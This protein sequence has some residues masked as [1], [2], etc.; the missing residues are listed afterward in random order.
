MRSTIKFFSSVKLAIV[1]L[2]IITLASILGTLVPQG[3]SAAE[4]AARYGQ[5][6]DLLIRLEVT[7]L[8][9]SWWYMGLLVMFALNIFVC[10]L[11]RLK[12]KLRRAFNPNLE[13]ESKK[14]ASLKIS[15]QWKVDQGTKTYRE[16]VNSV[17]RSKRFRILE[18][19]DEGKLFFLARKK[20]LGVFGSDIVHLG[21]LIII[22]GGI[23]SGMAGFK[24]TLKI[25]EGQ[26]ISVPKK[27]FSLRL[28]KF[29]TE[30]YENGSVKDW[31]STL[32]VVESDRDVLSKVVEVNHPLTHKGVVF[33][34]S[35]Y[36]WDW[37]D[38]SVEIRLTDKSDESVS[39]NITLKIGEKAVLSDRKLE[40]H[41][42]SF[43]P[44]FIL[45]EKNEVATRSREPNN[46]A[47]FIKVMKEGNEIFSGWLFARYRDFARM[48]S[49]EESDLS[50][51]FTDYKAGRFSGIQMAI[52]PGVNLIWLGCIFL[53][54]GLMIAFYWTPSEI[55][56]ILEE[57][58]G[59]TQVVLGGLAQKNTESFKQEFQK[60]VEKIRR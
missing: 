58:K 23:Y 56:V 51:N 16:K 25:S 57:E 37:S 55:R 12:P 7:R 17:L 44:D 30:Y 33:Y 24:T 2:I 13:F 46:P 28:D 31:K 43:V 39:E 15:G 35:S 53:M 59:K 50:F 26:V 22:A 8:Y 5:M 52:D 42:L 3:R 19:E 27:D 18:N 34:Q 38:P 47:V 21:L 9:Q 20:R 48:H 45:N 32:A 6:S 49:Q 60:I 1:L 40:L 54:L 4:Y 11:T 29:E 41:A 14:L 36:G 10:T